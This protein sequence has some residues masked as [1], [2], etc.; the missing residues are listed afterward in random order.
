VIISFARGDQNAPNPGVTAFLRYG[1]LAD[2]AT[3]FRADLAWAANPNPAKLEKNA[4]AFLVRMNTPERTVFALQ[5]QQQIT[6]FFAS[7]GADVID[8]DG[9]AEML[10]TPANQLPEDYGFIP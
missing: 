1:D 3:L 6:A 8:P 9:S 4:H 10:E 2:R 7:D 5:A